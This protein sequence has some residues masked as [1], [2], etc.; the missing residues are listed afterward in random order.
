MK[1]WKRKD[2]DPEVTAVLK[3]I[4][5]DPMGWEF[6]GDKVEHPSGIVIRCVGEGSF[7]DPSAHSPWEKVQFGDKHPV[8]T[9]RGQYRMWEALKRLRATQIDVIAARLDRG[10]EALAIRTL[11]KTQKLAS[12]E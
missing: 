11:R 9:G 7:D 4:E 10:D 6:T 2:R 12:G 5:A 8:L 1:F 3:L